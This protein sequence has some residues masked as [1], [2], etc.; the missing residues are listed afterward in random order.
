MTRGEQGQ[1]G[2][3]LII[4]GVREDLLRGHMLVPREP[5]ISV[6]V[7]VLMAEEAALQAAGDA[8]NLSVQDEHPIELIIAH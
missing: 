7:R 8:D 5:P 4:D 2:L 6:G 3:L 1:Q